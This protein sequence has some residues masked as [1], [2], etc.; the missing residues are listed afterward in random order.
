MSTSKSGLK[1]GQ[2]KKPLAQKFIQRKLDLTAP[3]IVI[4]YH[5]SEP[6]K[7]PDYLVINE[8]TDPEKKEFT[9]EELIVR[10]AEFINISPAVVNLFGLVNLDMKT[11]IP[12]NK[13]ITIPSA[14]TA[15]NDENDATDI[16]FIY[17]WRYRFPTDNLQDKIERTDQAA[18]SYIFYQMQD[19]FI[20]DRLIDLYNQQIEVE[21][22]LG[23]SV[24]CAVCYASS[25]NK[26]YEQLKKKS[27]TFIPLK[28]R[29]NF[30]H[31][32]LIKM[33]A[34][35]YE[36]LKQ[37]FGQTTSVTRRRF[38]KGFLKDASDYLTEEFV[39]SD[40]KILRV[41]YE[42]VFEY[43]NGQTQMVCTIDDLMNCNSME[44]EMT[45]LINTKTP[46][47]P[48]L[49]KFLKVEQAET[50]LSCLD[51]Y[52]RL[53]S[54][55]YT[56]PCSTRHGII[57]PPSLSR[58]K[59]L[60]CHGPI[61]ELTVK[62]K[63]LPAAVGSYLIQTDIKLYRFLVVMAMNRGK[64]HK[65]K[66][67]MMPNLDLDKLLKEYQESERFELVSR[68]SPSQDEESLLLCKLKKRILEEDEAESEESENYFT[69]IEATVNCIPNNYID[70]HE[71]QLLGT[72]A[73]TD[74]YRA[75]FKDA[76]NT[77]LSNLCPAGM[78]VKRLKKQYLREIDLLEGLQRGIQQLMHVK[79]NHIQKV[80]GVCLVPFQA[81][82]EFAPL[83]LLSEYLVEN[84]F[85]IMFSHLF[86]A[87]Y[88]IISAIEHLEKL[89]IV[90]GNVRC[91]NVLVM[92][93]KMY[94]K[95]ADPGLASV[96]STL[97]HQHDLYKERLPWLS[98]E[99]QSPGVIPVYTTA[100]DIFSYG[101]FLWELFSLAQ[102][103]PHVPPLTKP[104]LCCN[105]E[106]QTR[107]FDIMLGCW[108]P[109]QERTSTQVVMRDIWQEILRVYQYHTNINSP[110]S[111]E[112]EYYY[113]INMGLLSPS[114]GDFIVKEATSSQTTIKRPNNVK[115]HPTIQPFLP[116]TTMSRDIAG[117]I[118]PSGGVGF[119][120]VQDWIRAHANIQPSD[121]FSTV[122]DSTDSQRPLLKQSGA[123]SSW[124][125]VNHGVISSPTRR[126]SDQQTGVS[127]PDSEESFATGTHSGQPLLTTKTPQSYKVRKPSGEK[128][129][130]I[131]NNVQFDET[132]LLLGQGHYGV[133]YKGKYE[134]KDVAIKTLRQRRKILEK[135]L[136]KEIEL[137]AQLVHK[138]IV[139]FLGM[140]V[141]DKTTALVMEYVANGSL[142]T[143]LKKNKDTITSE[144]QLRWCYEIAQGMLYLNS[145]KIIH[146]DLAARNVLIDEKL[147]AKISDF[148]LARFLD[149]ERDYYRSEKS[150][151]P[152]F[153]TA[154]E[155]L[156]NHKFTSEGD[157]WSYGIV[158]WEIFT[159]GKH[160]NELTPKHVP[161]EVT[162]TLKAGIRL[163]I[164]DNVPRQV[165]P[166]I[167]RC[168]EYEY[169]KRPCF[170][171]IV[172]ILNTIVENQDN[173]G[174][175][176]NS[177]H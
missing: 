96:Y 109:W 155:G 175:E 89:R 123:L 46:R 36:I 120:H 65:H 134:G 88:N 125:R 119:D 78:V 146:R 158:A 98:P 160:P 137:M 69:L 80:F 94:C 37:N 93:E 91:R 57:G 62:S 45:V 92:E 79:H 104:D 12:S 75:D 95:L 141:K 58:L 54:D 73:A 82:I 106:K 27:L 108:K 114:S 23:L 169:Q 29:K 16:K 136:I 60:R 63:L 81:L 31:I 5:A 48:K 20:S 152:A 116:A 159:K 33:K 129:P 130:N 99:V 40:E 74:V 167:K 111:D 90:H 53:I 9:I 103:P 115:I 173:N 77:S 161:E 41:S 117:C 64:L 110:A 121:S 7:E 68:I 135:D 14:V 132:C 143:Y 43:Q 131:L 150:E 13:R 127:S 101:T 70:V 176:I 28:T 18:L 72:G 105:E 61:T 15:S 163:K 149:P 59:R 66:F 56:Q 126:G 47:P 21:K 2:T 124:S 10:A 39:L 148:G 144:S 34:N 49:F 166:L 112:H 51:G 145:Q 4:F 44:D 100:V 42:G 139:R 55:Y 154:P 30:E 157:V 128:H 156:L 113:P 118:P 24:L 86:W 107:M 52:Y 171:E 35:Y 122:T 71:N 172:D 153:W 11:W 26:T 17:R 140:S 76:V 102:T 50:F 97:P 22:A 177:V 174:C 147:C 87:S 165:E 170:S 85:D 25:E 8:Q 164:P 32:S 142:E 84:R 162:S 138:N 151:I 1:M 168:W 83:G 133:V 67:E 6:N 19:D 3:S 38:M